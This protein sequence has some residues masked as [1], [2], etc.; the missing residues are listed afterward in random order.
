MNVKNA[1]N[2]DRLTDY[3]LAHQVAVQ[4]IQV[5]LFVLSMDLHHQ[6]AELRYGLPTSGTQ[7]VMIDGAV[8]MDT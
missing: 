6:Q 7:F 8:M 5:D 3:V 1:L 4:S 2:S